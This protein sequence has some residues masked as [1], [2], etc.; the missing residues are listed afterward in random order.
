MGELTVWF[1]AAYLIQD[2]PARRANGENVLHTGNRHRSERHPKRTT[3]SRVGSI[4]LLC[5]VWASLL[6]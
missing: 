5:R 1:R 3:A 2:H 6:C 4:A